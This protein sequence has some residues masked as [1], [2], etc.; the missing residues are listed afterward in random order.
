MDCL[1]DFEL[2]F[3]ARGHENKTDLNHIEHCK[4][5][6]KKL[7]KYYFKFLM[8][9]NKAWG[10]E[11]NFPHLNSILLAFGSA[12]VTILLFGGFL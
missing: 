11:K 4:K 7:N 3:M 5:C 10:Y 12:F 8:N 2:K 9:T 6:R 1:N